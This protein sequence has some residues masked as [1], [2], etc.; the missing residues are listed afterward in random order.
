[1][2]ISRL[3]RAWFYRR[4]EWKYLLIQLA[5]VKR[6]RQVWPIRSS[7]TSSKVTARERQGRLPRIKR[8]R[9]DPSF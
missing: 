3:I 7:A 6:I 9:M 8:M 2:L 1:M 4:S 5:W